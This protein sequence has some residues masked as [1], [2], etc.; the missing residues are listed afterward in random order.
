M[1]RFSSNKTISSVLTI[2]L[3]IILFIAVVLLMNNVKSLL[4]SDTKINLQEVAIQN[5]D[6][7]TSKLQLELNSLEL[8][9][10]QL[11]DNMHARE[12]E[13]T[14]ETVQSVF[15]T[16]GAVNQ[17]PSLFVA[18]S[19][20]D[21]MFIDGRQLSIAGRKY[22][23]LSSLGTPNISDRVVSRLNGQEVFI[24]SVP[25]LMDDTVVGTIQKMYSPE[26]MYQLCAI[27]LFSSQGYMNIVNSDG[28]ILISSETNTYVEEN[29]NYFRDLYAK[30]NQQQAKTLEEDIKNNR[31]GFMETE[32]DGKKIFSAY[33][34]IEEVHDWFLIS[35]V[36]TAAV[37][38]NANRVIKIFYVILSVVVIIFAVSMGYF[39][40]YKNRQ[41]ANLEQVA[42]LD[43][44]TMGL[45]YA[46]F[47][48]DTKK[49][50][51]THIDKQFSLLAFD[52]DNFRY[53]NNFYGF[54]EGD[55]ILRSI[56]TVVSQQLLPQ[57]LLCRVSGDHFVMLV[58]DASPLRINT[59]L[60]S[61]QKAGQYTIYVSGGLYPI[62]DI[63]ESP[64]L[65]MDKAT[66]AAQAVKGVLHK[67]METY[68]DK[69]EKQMIENEQTKRLVEQAIADDE[70][71]PYYQPKVYINTEALAGAEVLARWRKKDGTIVPPAEFIPMCERTG[72]IT[73]LDMVIFE[74]ALQFIKRHL[75]KGVRCV[76]ISVN[77]S[78]LHLSDP[79]FAQ[80]I[81]EKINHYGIPP[82]LIEIELTENVIMDNHD[83][84]YDFINQLHDHGVL[85]SMDDFGSGY[86][87]L[88]M[89]KDLPI[90]VI[91]IDR[92]FLKETRDSN[93]KR[94]IFSTIVQ[95]ARKL[96]MK[97]VV[98][99]VEN[100]ENLQLMRDNG[101]YIAQG[102]YF[103]KPVD[104]QSFEKY[105]KIG[106]LT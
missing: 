51:A 30:G 93:R 35:S 82:N 75:D 106:R 15:L 7:I 26:E 65:M 78:R 36:S 46:K 101:C 76:P 98:E 9:A 48:V 11:A 99:G 72:L 41:Q 84:V 12:L 6:V 81:I 85:M 100:E 62:S 77:F 54:D 90:D 20:G 96:E 14:P 66:T 53:I 32:I 63:N 59:L 13:P 71:L 29:D 39:L 16:Y 69:Y 33:T 28:Y 8:L 55:N 83:V 57:E 104:E 58:E 4:Y 61:V 43:P 70:M 42:F 92:G 97:I 24:I 50:L 3:N 38:S 74:K 103:S 79:N 94:I 17:D 86:S 102:F 68:S 10:K 89:L 1:A 31:A 52:I 19:T 45:T 60:D 23:N 88:N 87:S 67:K 40:S 27:S 34:P 21:A 25:L 105:Y 80:H 47:V 56:H 73:E 91:K 2:G 22:F 18:S 49:M 64:N 44:V 95:M 5:K 37:S